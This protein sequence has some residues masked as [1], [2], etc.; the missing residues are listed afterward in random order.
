MSGGFAALLDDLRTEQA[1]QERRARDAQR[2]RIVDPPRQRQSMGMLAKAFS[3][4]T[5]NVRGMLSRLDAM[6]VPTAEDARARVRANVR[7]I[8]AR[9]DASFKAGKINGTELATIDVHARRI[10]DQLR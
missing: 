6:E 2:A 8:L 10:L 9:A 5:T 4:M 3:D 1:A 7:D